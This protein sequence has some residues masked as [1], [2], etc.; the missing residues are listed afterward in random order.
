MNKISLYLRIAIAL[1]AIILIS[2]LFPDSGFQ[3]Y[4]Y[5]LGKKWDYKDLY[6]PKDFA[7]LKDLKDVDNEKQKLI[8]GRELVFLKNADT[9]QNVIER[10]QDQIVQ[11]LE[12]KKIRF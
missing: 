9:E 11:Y 7:I 8:K 5:E 12:E 6:A 4:K 2:L 3:K 1:G 10:V